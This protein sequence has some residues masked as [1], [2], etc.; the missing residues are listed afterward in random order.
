[1]KKNTADDQVT[2]QI[3]PAPKIETAS[4]KIKGTAPYMQAQFSE[5]TQNMLKEKMSSQQTGKAKKNR[6]A[7]DFDADVENAK[8]ISVEGWCGIPASAFRVAMISACRLVGFKM[9]LAKLSVFVSADGYDKIDGQP[10]IKIEGKPE[11][12]DLPVRNATGVMDIRARP[13]WREWT[14]T[15]SIKYDTQQFSRG[16]VQNLLARVGLQVGVGEGRPD[17]R[18]S[19]GLGYGLFEI[20]A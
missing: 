10:L 1:M 12:C 20:V 3:I 14:A 8:H 6:E 16:D 18:M 19:A 9:T 4:F 2:Q 7:R 5:K 17:S 13:L 11:R 15:V